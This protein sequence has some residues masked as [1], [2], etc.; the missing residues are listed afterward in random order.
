MAL[1]P[2]EPFT[3]ASGW[4]SPIYCDNRLTMADPALR[5][6]LT[7]GFAAA[8]AERGLVPDTIAGTA[9]AGIPHAAWLAH[10]MRLPMVYVRSK[11]KE[12]GKGNQIEGRLNENARVVLVEDTVST[13]GSALDAVEALRAAGAEVLAVVAIFAYRFPQAEAAFS[14]A[15][16]PLLAL[17]DYDSLIAEAQA[18]GL[19][20]AADLAALRAWRAD[21]AGWGDRAGG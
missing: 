17:T 20:S 8:L 12:H 4:K 7:E 19:V 15:G 16:V 10:R 2:H 14:E 21:P 6:R 5:A 11:A 1:R 9:T 18:T 3:W 13:G